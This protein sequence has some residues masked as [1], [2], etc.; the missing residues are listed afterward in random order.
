MDED[1]KVHV[2][3]AQFL[4]SYPSEF[5]GRDGNEVKGHKIAVAVLMDGELFRVDTHFLSAFKYNMCK[6]AEMA[7]GE[8]IEYNYNMKQ[9]KL[10]F[11]GKKKA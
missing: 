4:A 3:T 7:T 11:I 6:I 8:E 9:K 2:W 1:I 5:I 10:F